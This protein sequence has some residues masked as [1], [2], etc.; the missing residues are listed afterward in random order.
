MI[1]GASLIA[2][3]RKGAEHLLVIECGGQG[4]RLRKNGR[5]SGTGYAMQGLI[6]PIVR[7]NTKSLDRGRGIHHLPDLFFRCQEREQVIY[8]LLHRQVW[9]LKRVFGLIATASGQE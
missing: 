5:A 2:D 1:F 6:P 4:D 7:W 3:H 8:P 9:I